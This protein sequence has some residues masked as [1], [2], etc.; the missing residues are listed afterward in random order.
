MEQ[1]VKRS[2]AFLCAGLVLLV[3]LGSSALVAESARAVQPDSS[4]LLQA[5]PV[6]LRILPAEFNVRPGETID[7]V[8]EVETGMRSV[9]GAAAYLDFDPGILQVISVVPGERMETVIQNRYDNQAGRLDF[10]AG[11]L[12]KSTTG[13]FV[14]VRITFQAIGEAS[15]SALHFSQTT[16][17]QSD[18]AGDGYSL[19]EQAVDGTVV[20]SAPTPTMTPTPTNTPVPPTPTSTPAPVMLETMHIG[21]L[22]GT[23]V[24][25]K[26]QWQVV[27]TITVHDAAERPVAN[28]TVRA[29][30]GE[31]LSGTVSCTTD[32]SGQCVVTSANINRKYSSVG[33]TVTGVTHARLAYQ[34]ADNRD[35]DGDSDGT[36]ITI[37]RAEIGASD[38]WEAGDG[39]DLYIPM[40]LKE[41]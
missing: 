19:L 29:A 17:R 1:Y 38:I 35:P 41:P 34:A 9:N 27:V 32:N 33:Y 39:M 13:T 5:T 24:A 14:L 26:N 31:G 12:G 25:R 11:L 18:V 28:A 10:A 20:V 2:A 16:P 23:G 8:V 36:R 40:L 30:W 21:D 3:V 7:A 6:V 4:A 22:D 37:A 15:S